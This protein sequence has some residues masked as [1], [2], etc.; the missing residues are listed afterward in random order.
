[1]LAG[2]QVADAHEVRRIALGLPHVEEIDCDGF[3]FR[4]PAKASCGPTPSTRRADRG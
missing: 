3:D 4:V 2:G 1:M